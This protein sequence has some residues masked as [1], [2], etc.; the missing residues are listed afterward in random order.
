MYIRKIIWLQISSLTHSKYLDNEK[1]K[2]KVLGAFVVG[3]VLRNIIHVYRKL[4]FE[5]KGCTAASELKV[6]F[7][8][9]GMFQ[10]NTIG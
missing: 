3:E 7:S 1:K 4:G 9:L 5:K 6:R 10:R 2:D 8:D